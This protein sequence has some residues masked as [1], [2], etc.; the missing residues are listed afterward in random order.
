MIQSTA[1][2]ISFG[3]AQNPH[4]FQYSPVARLILETR[5]F[6]ACAPFRSKRNG[7]AV[8]RNA[9]FLRSLTISSQTLS[10]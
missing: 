10:V 6:G 5:P 3:S 7:P 8:R 2:G 4:V 1:L 9:S